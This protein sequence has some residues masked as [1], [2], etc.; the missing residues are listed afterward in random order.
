[1]ERPPLRCGH[2]FA[3]QPRCG[4]CDRCYTCCNCPHKRAKSGEAVELPEAV[5]QVNFEMSIL[6]EQ[7][8][9]AAAPTDG[10]AVI[11]GEISRVGRAQDRVL[12]TCGHENYFF[13]WS[14]AGHGRAKCKG[15]GSWIYYRTC[16]VVPVEEAS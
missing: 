3:G 15:C 2:E 5:K 6:A 7:F 4:L 16:E 1:M 13:R 14:W 10:H 11:I 8:K 12:C 9:Q